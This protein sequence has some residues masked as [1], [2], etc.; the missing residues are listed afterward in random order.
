MKYLLAAFLISVF[1]TAE[2]ADIKTTFE[3]LGSAVVCISG[4]NNDL[5]TNLVWLKNNGVKFRNV[6]RPTVSIT[7]HS[8]DTRLNHML[9]VTISK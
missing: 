9:C 1:S 6:S 2:S 8:Y 5:N 7:G 3:L 4:D